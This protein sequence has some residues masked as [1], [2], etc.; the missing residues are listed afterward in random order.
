MTGLTG[1]VPQAPK[2]KRHGYTI[3]ELCVS[4]STISVLIALFAML[5]AST[6]EG[7]LTQRLRAVALEELRNVF[8]RIDS[9]DPG[10]LD[11]A[12]LGAPLREALPDG[13]LTLERIPCRID[14]NG[15]IAPLADL[16]ANGQDEKDGQDE[17]D[18]QD[19]RAETKNLLALRVT[20]SW[21]NGTGNIRPELSL[22]RLVFP[23]Q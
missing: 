19:G 23:K 20:V 7:R 18:G 3:L 12:E 5:A 4:V 13:R 21:D 14:E 15:R 6:T 10:S 2:M 16:P 22:V 11:E 9:N 1:S 17:Q 8:E